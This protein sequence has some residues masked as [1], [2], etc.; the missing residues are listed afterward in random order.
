[1]K[2]CAMSDLHGH[3]P[4]VPPCDLLIV[5]GDSCVDESCGFTARVSDGPR[6]QEAWFRSRWLPYRHRQPA[7]FC[8]VGWGNHCYAG[9][10]IHDGR[11][12]VT[13]DS[14]TVSVVDSDFVVTIDG[15]TLRLWVTPVTTMG[16][17]WAFK[18]SEGEFARRLSRMPDNVDILVSHVPPFG[19]VDSDPRHEIQMCEGSR[20]LSDAIKEKRPRVVVCGHIHDAYGRGA[21]ARYLGSGQWE[22]TQ[23]Y[24]VA[25]ANRKY[26][27]AH[28]VTEFDL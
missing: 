2:I 9:E 11:Q 24:N 20:A 7:A 25:L 22:R 23:V 16:A 5:A 15:Q 8:V 26:E 13:Y 27:L 28:A 4:P 6:R 10:V 21:I 14:A 18:T 17:D 12:V 19:C 1:M 3:M